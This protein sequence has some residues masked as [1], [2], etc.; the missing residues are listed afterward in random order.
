MSRLLDPPG[1]VGPLQVPCKTPEM[2]DHLDEKLAKALR[3]T[4]ILSFSFRVNLGRLNK[5]QW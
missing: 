5:A 2:T 1:Y 4:L 3:G